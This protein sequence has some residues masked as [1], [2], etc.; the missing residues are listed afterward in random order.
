MR[1]RLA[2]P[3]CLQR[4]APPP[5]DF[6]LR[7]VFGFLEFVSSARLLFCV[8]VCHFGPVDPGGGIGRTYGSGFSLTGHESMNGWGRVTRRE[9]FA[10]EDVGGTILQLRSAES[11]Q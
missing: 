10:S 4:G 5:F 8:C 1:R 7:N 6:N 11:P 3:A 2:C 9:R